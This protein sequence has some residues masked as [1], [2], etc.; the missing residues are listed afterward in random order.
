MKIKTLKWSMFVVTAIGN[1]IAMLDSSSVTLALYPMSVDLHVTLNQIQWIMI[2]YM[3]ILTVFLPF[4]GKLGDIFSKNKLYSTGFAIFAIGALLSSLSQTYAQLIGFRCLEAIGAS[5]M[6]SNAQAIIA[7]IFKGPRR[8][9]ALGLNGCF[10][11][12]GGV[13]GPALGGILIHN[14]GRHFIFLPSVITGILGFYY[15]KKLLPHH[16]NTEIQNFKFDYKGFIYFTI[17]LFALLLAI[18]QGHE[19][20]WKSVKI[21]ILGITTLIFGGLFYFRDHKINYPIINFKLFQIRT[22]TFGN[23]AVMTAYM[24]MFSNSILLPF[25]LQEIQGQDLR[26]QFKAYCCSET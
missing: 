1:F 2:A 9:K 19:W 20:G 13:T 21:I 3:L 14:F 26:Y 12:I 25:F 11:A 24:A 22:F 23:L 18:A 7:T 15:A 16:R 17:S 5:I 6:L 4:F 10:V 8:G